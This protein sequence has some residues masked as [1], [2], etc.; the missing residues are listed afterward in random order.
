MRFSMTDNAAAV[1]RRAVHERFV[2][3]KYEAGRM[4]GWG[5]SATDAAVQAGQMP[6][7]DG[8]KQ[9]VPTAWLRR[10]LQLDRDP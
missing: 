3:G 10:Q 7:I 9:T 6:I 1:L 5:R 2:V 8:P 4:L